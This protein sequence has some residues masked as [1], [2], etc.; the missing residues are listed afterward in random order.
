MTTWL[1]GS[2]Q[3]GMD[4]GITNL[5]GRISEAE[6][7]SVLALC[8]DAGIDTIDTSPVYGDAEFRI[9]ALAPAFAVQT[10]VTIA[11]HSSTEVLA[12]LRESLVRLRRPTV[13]TVL[14]HDWPSLGAAGRETAVSALRAAREEGL[15]L[16][17]GVSAYDEADLITALD[18]FDRLD[19]VQMPVSVLDQ[20]L[21]D[22]G[23]VASLH[24]RGGRLQARS[25]LLQGVLAGAGAPFESHPDVQRWVASGLGVGGALTYV[26]SRPWVEEVVIGV[27][28]SSELQAL[29]AARDVDVTNVDWASFASDDPDLIDPRRWPPR[30]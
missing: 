25:V 8:A 22:S 16:G 18:A 6:V 24:A 3:W 28:A 17:V 14:V 20:R 9:G 29:L 15:T 5:S 23:S 10:K 12:G 2:A 4:Y 11:D 26:R 13:E 21:E 19:V 30:S 7:V 1:I 27:A